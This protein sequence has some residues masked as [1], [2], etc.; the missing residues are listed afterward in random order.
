ME[1]TSLRPKISIAMGVYNCAPTLPEAIDSI[2]SQTYQDWELIICDDGSKDET[3]AIA[4][5]YAQ[6]DSRI[7]VI[8]NPKNMGLNHSLNH[9]LKVSRGVYYARMDGDDISIPERLSR[10]ATTLD[11][12]PEVAL[13]SSWMGCFDQGGDWAV[14]KTQPLPDRLDFVRGSPFCHAPCMM[15]KEALEKVGGYGTEP[16]QRRVEDYHLWFKLYAAGYRGMNLPEVLY[17][18]RDDRAAAR[19]R[20]LRARLEEARVMWNGFRQLHIPFWYYPLILKPILLG[21]M[22]LWLYEKLRLLRH[23]AT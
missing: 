16:W 13:V 7:I 4:Q 23:S 21:L 11:S 6:K 14:I 8:Q 9:C 10:L 20:N 17:K 3:L 18:M 19:R 1:S 2:I 12:H 22:P 15:R 5:A